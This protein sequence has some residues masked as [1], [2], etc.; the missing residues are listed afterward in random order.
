MYCSNREAPTR[1]WSSIQLRWL[2]LEA[3]E[4]PTKKNAHAIQWAAKKMATK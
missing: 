4:L 1:F 2:P 3:S